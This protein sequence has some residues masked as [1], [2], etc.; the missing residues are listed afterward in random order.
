MVPPSRRQCCF[1]FKVNFSYL[2][3][4]VCTTELRMQLFFIIRLCLVKNRHLVTVAELSTLFT[5]IIPAYSDLSTLW[6]WAIIYV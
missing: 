5:E 4:I 3:Y 2:K 6:V 1:P